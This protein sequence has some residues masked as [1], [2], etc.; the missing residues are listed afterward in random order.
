MPQLI[1]TPMDEAAA[2]LGSDL[3]RWRERRGFSQLDQAKETSLRLF[4]TIAT[5]GTPHDVTLQEI[6]VEC[7]SPMDDPT[8]E[9]FR[10]WGRG[11]GGP[12]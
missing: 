12:V 5:L 8:A 6:R 11:P 2:S 10:S 1:T 3:R 4:T 9:L 7:F